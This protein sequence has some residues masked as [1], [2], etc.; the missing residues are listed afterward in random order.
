MRVLRCLLCLWLVGGVHAGWAY[1]STERTSVSIGLQ[2]PT[3]LQIDDDNHLVYVTYGTSF[4]IMD[5]G[6]FALTTP[7][8]DLTSEK[9]LNASLQ[10]IA[11][12]ALNKKLF[13]TQDGGL[14]LTY[15]LSALTDKPTQATIAAGKALTRVVVDPVSGLPYLLNT[16]D[17]SVLTY[18]PATGAVT[19]LA[20]PKTTGSSYTVLD[21]ILV[22][23]ASG[24]SSVLYLT[25]NDGQLFF[26]VAGATAV[27]T[28]VLDT[29]K[30]DDLTAIA[31]HPNSSK[32][33][34]TNTSLKLVHVVSVATNTQ[35]T[36][37]SLAQNADLKSIVVTN[38][39]NPSDTYGFVVGSK[40]L[41]VFDADSFTVLD[42]GSK[43]DVKEEPLTLSG[44]GALVPSDDGYLFNFFGNVG[45]ISD[46]P[47]VTVNSVTY[48]SGKTAL[49]SGETVAISF[50]ADEAGT[51]DLRIGGT[52]EKNGASL[53]DTA[54]ASTGTVSAANTAQ[55]LTIAYSDNSSLWSEGSNTV[56]LFAKDSAGN[57]GRRATTISVDTPPPT[58][59]MTGAGFGN[60]KLYVNLKRLAVADLSSYRIYADTDATVVTTK[61]AVAGSTSQPSAGTDPT[62]TISGLSNGSSYFLAAE[63]VDTKG[64]VSPTR[65]TTFTSGAVASSTPEGT[66]GPAGLAGEAGCTLV[67][68]RPDPVVLEAAGPA[69]HWTLEMRGGIYQPTGT[70]MKSFFS[71]CCNPTANLS[72]GY[73]LSPQFGVELGAGYFL[74]SGGARGNLSGATAQERFTLWLVPMQLEGVYRAVYRKEQL[75]VPFVKAG[76]DLIYFHEFDD[77]VTI[78]GVK[79]GLH[80]GGGLMLLLNNFLEGG[81]GDEYG[82][83][84]IYL[85]IDGRYQW[86]NNFGGG[87]L[88][89]SGW[90]ATGGFQ[91]QF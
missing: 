79:G 33:Y 54:G 41:S 23:N 53:K 91:L 46:N 67:V 12:D 65:S 44:S 62:V 42:L 7:A 28:L 86:V 34:V 85:V 38:V 35:S 82:I 22:R 45:V 69:E 37:I 87:G 55:T 47:F 36:T 15:N 78:K 14:L 68:R 40:G 9:T 73:Q 76:T 50:Q 57:E 16:T 31:A 52:V 88:D 63:A 58:V 39:T 5:L 56:F 1:P 13:A 17:L 80:G 51:Y 64:N 21:M 89:L 81:L 29:K 27:N 84:D 18:N 83:N 71:G 48:S 59:E 26:F 11:F 61:T 20:L 6:T 10:G 74:Q 90:S 4:Q 3:G 66:F 72:G 19:T 2:A 25:T 70:A 8:F 75:V 43:S 49:A 24:T 77:A 60:Q 32:I 30:T